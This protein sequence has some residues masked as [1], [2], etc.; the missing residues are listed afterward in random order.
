MTLILLLLC[1]LEFFCVIFTDNNVNFVSGY[2]RK[3]DRMLKEK[4]RQRVNL[5][6]NTG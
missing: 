2:S 6:Y 5:Q 3:K 4:S 1:Q